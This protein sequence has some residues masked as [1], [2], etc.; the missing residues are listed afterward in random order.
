M[1]VLVPILTI[2]SGVIL[3]LV[4]ISLGRKAKASLQ[5]PAAPGTVVVSQLVE[6][7]AGEISSYLPLVT[8]T[9]AVNGQ[10]FQSSRVGF[11]ASKSRK[12]LAKYPKGNAVQVFFDPQ[13]PATSVLEKGGSTRFMV[14]IGIALIIGGCVAGFVMI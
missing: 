13:Q 11:V 9:Y 12:V 1:M 5:W 2:L 4:A 6:D 8:Y 10:A 3:I 14:F 7:T